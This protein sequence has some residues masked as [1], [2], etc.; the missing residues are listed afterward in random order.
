MP[1][2]SPLP[3]RAESVRPALALETARGIKNAFV[4]GVWLVELGALEDP[5]HVAGAI[6]SVLGVSDAAI[7]RCKPCSALYE[8]A[9]SC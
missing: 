4:D 1:G 9:T 8:L 3:E 2:S 7:A 6:A 5:G